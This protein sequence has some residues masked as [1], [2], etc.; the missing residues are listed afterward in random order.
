MNS[1]DYTCPHAPTNS[2]NPTPIIRNRKIAFSEN[3]TKN[4]YLKLFRNSH[5]LTEAMLR[6]YETSNNS[7]LFEKY[8]KQMKFS[9]KDQ[10]ANNTNTKSE[11]NT[12][13]HRLSKIEEGERNSSSKNRKFSQ[14]SANSQK[15]H[16][17]NNILK[18]NIYKSVINQCINNLNAEKVRANQLRMELNRMN[19]KIPTIAYVYNQ[20]HFLNHI[21]LIILCKSALIINDDLFIDIIKISWSLLLNSDQEIS[22]S[23]GM[24][25]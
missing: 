17:I 2:A 15:I 23:A 13:Q 5:A 25:N 14:N 1:I 18:R 19:E 7:S 20:V 24:F 16:F 21:P 3:C 12:Q 10:T 6:I 11:K 8:Q 4:C 9:G 22:S